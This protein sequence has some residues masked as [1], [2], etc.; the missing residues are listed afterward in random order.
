MLSVTILH[1][2][3]KTRELG[4]WYTHNLPYAMSK[5]VDPGGTV[6]NSSGMI[7]S[8]ISCNRGNIFSNFTEWMFIICN[9]I[10]NYTGC[11]CENQAT[12]ISFLLLW[13]LWSFFSVSSIFKCNTG[14]TNDKFVAS[15][16]IF[17]PVMSY[18]RVQKEKKA[19]VA[20]ANLTQSD[21]NNKL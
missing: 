21:L 4:C 8:V 10:C 1:Q 16:I 14:E 5:L 20:K 18:R 7:T 2:C 19:K 13:F 12:W 6:S 9:I 3:R 15:L 17:N 11:F